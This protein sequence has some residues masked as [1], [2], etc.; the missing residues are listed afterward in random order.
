MSWTRMVRFPD[1]YPDFYIN[2]NNGVDTAYLKG[3]AL[4]S[5]PGKYAVFIEW[6]NQRFIHRDGGPARY[7]H[8][9][10]RKEDCEAM[11]RLDDP[12]L[13]AGFL[14]GARCE[15][16]ILGNAVHYGL[17]AP[18]FDS[19]FIRGKIASEP[20]EWREWLVVARHLGV[21]DHGLRQFENAAGLIDFL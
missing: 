6:R 14:N 20:R 9:G 16:W 8:E 4:K 1:E 2:W 3:I 13:L 12:T 17:E 15:W 5:S 7:W 21:M 18:V 10:L 19:E 11:S